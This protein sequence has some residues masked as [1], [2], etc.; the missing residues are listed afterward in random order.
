MFTW[1]ALAMAAGMHSR[2]GTHGEEPATGGPMQP[3]VLVP[4]FTSSVRL[5]IH[6]GS[7]PCRSPPPATVRLPGPHP[8]S[9]RQCPCS[10]EIILNPCSHSCLR[11]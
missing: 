3:Y 5:S 4:A 2:G 9:C 7:G 1:P 8:W 6:P 10:S 11:Y